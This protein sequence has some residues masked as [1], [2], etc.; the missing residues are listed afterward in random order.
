MDVLRESFKISCEKN[1]QK[2][3]D[4]KA[5]PKAKGATKAGQDLHKAEL[6][7]E[8]GGHHHL[9]RQDEFDGRAALVAVLHHPVHLHL[10]SSA[11]SRAEGFCVAVE[12]SISL[13]A[14]NIAIKAST[15]IR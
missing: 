15:F 12:V 11:R 14:R 4:S 3:E 8:V 10:G 5:K 1:L 13:G 9:V 7:V 2:L 6:G